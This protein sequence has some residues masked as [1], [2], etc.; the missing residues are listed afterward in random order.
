MD[1]LFFGGTLSVVPHPSV[2]PYTPPLASVFLE[3]PYTGYTKRMRAVPGHPC[4]LPG[5]LTTAYHTPSMWFAK[6]LSESF[7]QDPAY[8]RKSENSF[9]R[10]PIL[11]SN[12]PDNTGFGPTDYETPDLQDFSTFQYKYPE[13]EV[14]MK[15]LQRRED[16]LEEYRDPWGAIYFQDVR[17]FP[18]VESVLKST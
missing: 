2:K 8:P 11:I 7:W 9:H 18:I 4:T 1:Q 10:T 15:E 12:S 5:A 13:D 16:M 17:L 6:M 14:I 3:F